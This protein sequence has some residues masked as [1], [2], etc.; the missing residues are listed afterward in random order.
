MKFLAH[1]KEASFVPSKTP[2]ISDGPPL[3][4]AD[5]HIHETHSTETDPFGSVGLALVL[6]FCFMLLVDQC[7]R[8]SGSSRDIEA[9]GLSVPRKSFTATLGLVV[10]AAGLFQFCSC[11]FN[12]NGPAFVCSETLNLS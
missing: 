10:H 2:L 7:S 3:V 4:P 1:G 8:S 5:Q 11:V 9:S 12:L 6:G